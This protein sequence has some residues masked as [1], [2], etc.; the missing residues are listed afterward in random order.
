MTGQ[1]QQGSRAL[2]LKRLG[3]MRFI[4]HQ[5]RSRRRKGVGQPSPAH[6]LKLNPKGL[7]FAAPVGMKSDGSYHKQA[8]L[9]AAHQGTGRQ[10]GRESLPQTHLIGQNGTATG[11]EPTDPGA[12]M[13]Q[14]TTAIF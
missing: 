11:Q 14:G 13:T 12:L 4:H 10:Q 3:V 6:Q 2:R 7:G 8:H 1:T 5:Q 9:G